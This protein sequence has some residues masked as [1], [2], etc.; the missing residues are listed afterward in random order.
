MQYRKLG[1][2]GW[3]VSEISFGAWAIGGTW[4]DVNDNESLE[5]LNIALDSGVNF[6]DTADVYGDGRSE[7]LL[8]KLKKERKE[9]FYIA[10][11][12][13]RRLDPHTADGY[14]RKNL[15]S[16]VERSLKNLNTDVIDLLQLHC[17]PTQVFYMP[18]VFG[19]LDDLVKEGKLIY[20]GVSVEKVE[21]ALKAIEY[22]NV[23]I[24]QI[25]FNMFRHRPSEFFFEQAKKKQVGILAR[26][27]LA[28]GMLA[29]KFTKDSKFEKDDHRRF[30]RHGEDFD[31][32]E[33]FSGVDYDLG[34]KAVEELKDI[35]PVGITLTQFALRWILM[36]DAVTCTIPGAKRKNQVEEN[37]SSVDLPPLTDETM[38]KVNAVYEKHIKE[39]VHQ[40][41]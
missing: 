23:Q 13:G 8:A 31:K 21:E 30:N 15:S 41:W 9:K 7:R 22:P 38:K 33:T 16:F 19:I 12:A 17:P 10:T 28:S 5:A 40:Y 36:F 27:P 25:I 34:L 14:N 11:K 32:G 29:G 18:Q 6:F 24:V 37:I 39:S 1:R 26:V 35:C 20:Y 4:G 2:T 3:K